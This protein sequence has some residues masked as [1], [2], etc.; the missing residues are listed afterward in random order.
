[1][2][3]KV[4]HFITEGVWNSTYTSRRMNWVNRQ[5]KVLIYTVNSAGRHNVVVRSAALTFYTV[6]SIVPVIALVFGLA[7]GFG[8]DVKLIDYLYREFGQSKEFIDQLIGL[9]D[10]VLQR[11]HGGWVATV[12]FVVLIWAVLRV[13]TNVENAFNN[14][15]EVK[16]SRAITRKF[17]DYLALIFVVPILWMISTSGS[18]YIEDTIVGLGNRY[19]LSTFVEI[20]FVALPIVSSWIMFSFV[21]YVMPAA[22]VKL[23]GAIMGGIIAGTALQ[24][25]QFF[26]VF[27]QTGVSG[28]NVVYGSLAAIPLFLIWLNISWQ[29]V[30][31]GAELSFAYQNIEKYEFEREASHMSYEYRRKI[32]IVA[33]HKITVNFIEHGGAM[34]AE[35]VANQQNLPVRLVRDAISELERAGLLLPVQRQEQK[36]SYYVPAVDAHTLRVYDVMAAIE[37]TGLRS[38]GMDECI[39][40]Q[41]VTKLMEQFSTLLSE[42]SNN[43]LLK[44]IKE[45]PC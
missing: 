35:E 38:S 2:I 31:I 28:M 1:M 42:S 13:F 22:N 24:V 3:K 29:I 20:L 44:D 37:K 18:V 43:L 25:F 16:K 7:K 39:D 32:E 14:I 23:G 4:K 17:S 19:G 12:G 36:S 5:L 41:S 15:W 26:Y 6:M 45:V 30:L 33:M 40:M 21:Y 8:L 11:T 9:A 34:S 27:S 10:G